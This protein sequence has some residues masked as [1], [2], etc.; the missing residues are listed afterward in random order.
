MYKAFIA[1]LGLLLITSVASAK[2][3]D[4]IKLV[5]NSEIKEAR[6]ENVANLSGETCGSSQKGVLKFLTTQEGANLPGLYV[7]DGSAW[8]S[9]GGGG[10]SSDLSPVLLSSTQMKI[11]KT[12]SE[13]STTYFMGQKLVL[14]SD[15][16]FTTGSN[17]S[18]PPGSNYIYD[19]VYWDL[20]LGGLGIHK[21]LFVGA[22]AQKTEAQ[23]SATTEIYSTVREMPL[24]YIEI[25]STGIT[26]VYRARPDVNQD[27]K[28]Y[29]LQLAAASTIKLYVQ[30]GSRW[31][32]GNLES[33]ASD[34]VFNVD[35]DAS[36]ATPD[37]DEM[38]KD[39]GGTLNNYFYYDV[40]LNK[41]V[42]FAKA[43]VDGSEQT[44]YAWDGTSRPDPK[45]APLGVVSVSA[46]GLIL[47]VDSYP[48]EFYAGW[49]STRVVQQWTLSAVDDAQADSDGFVTAANADASY[50]HNLD[51]DPS[52]LQ[53]Q[54]WI[55]ESGGNIIP[56][57]CSGFLA[58]VATN[59]LTRT[60]LYTDVTGVPAGASIKYM[61]Y[62]FDSGKATPGKSWSTCEASQ[63]ADNDC[64]IDDSEAAFAGDITF[65][66][67]KNMDKPICTVFHRTSGGSA[68]YKNPGAGL[69]DIELNSLKTNSAWTSTLSTVNDEYYIKC[70]SSNSGNIFPDTIALKNV[71]M[72]TFPGVDATVCASGCSNAT[73]QDAI[74]GLGTSGGVI[75]FIDGE[76]TTGVTIAAATSNLTI[77]SYGFAA[78]TKSDNV[79]GRHAITIGAG[80][81]NIKVK[82]LN[83]IS[84]DDTDDVI[85]FDTSNDSTFLMI[86]E[87]RMDSDTTLEHNFTVGNNPY[88]YTNN[89]R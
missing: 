31:I 61:V 23:I 5:D 42:V 71:T 68:Q 58:A 14:V 16:T 73:L 51:Y 17:L 62:Y 28:D 30:A 83:F 13:G 33:E 18:S 7:C 32:D 84:W 50:T 29:G 25:D 69:K 21:D 75:L 72:Q 46:A 40:E 8:G 22:A 3:F 81:S 43:W 55:K 76:S 36:F 52:L 47:S 20:D 10:G 67:G 48:G 89:L 9:A 45:Y 34:T 41:P 49:V 64:W 2:K 77:M 19:Y 12:D 35:V 65:T 37:E 15:I 1:I 60:T 78:L 39:A 85:F 87:N 53:C 74:T 66:H 79:T 27:P 56:Q 4:G 38:R 59:G 70:S 88:N 80:S 57:E 11:N 54:A 63:D 6:I 26:K 44:D 86:T 24:A 82:G